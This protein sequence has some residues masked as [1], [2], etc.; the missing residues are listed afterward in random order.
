MPYSINADPL[1]RFA[2]NFEDEP[3]FVHGYRMAPE[4]A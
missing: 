3:A 1:G 2:I 4:T